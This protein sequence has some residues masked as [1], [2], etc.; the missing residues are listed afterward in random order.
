[1]Y[2]INN[3]S[4]F[5][6]NIIINANNHGHNSIKIKK[7][8]IEIEEIIKKLVLI[9]HK[10]EEMVTIEKVIIEVIELIVRCKI[11]K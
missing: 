3:S 7:N 5:H 1:M 4:N 11:K 9:D 10:K 8:I 6:N 2:K